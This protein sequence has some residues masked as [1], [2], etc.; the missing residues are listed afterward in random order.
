MDRSKA[1]DCLPHELLIAK[2]EA[3]GLC[4]T[5]LKLILDY[6]S[7]RKQRVKLGNIT[8]SWLELLLGVPQG[9]IHGPL[10]F[11]IFI[12]DIFLFLEQTNICNFADDNTIYACDTAIETVISR[13]EYDMTKIMSWFKSNSMAANTAKFQLMFLGIND[14]KR[15]CLDINNNIVVGCNSVKLLGVTIDHRLSFSST[16]RKYVIKPIKKQ[17]PCYV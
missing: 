3:Y 12:N 2:L 6:L 14:N 7:N 11:N 13:L 1:Y 5:S 8:S 17:R 15:L 10:L 16:S 4:S 9:S